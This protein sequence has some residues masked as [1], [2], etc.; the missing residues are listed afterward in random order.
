MATRSMPDFF[1]RGVEHRSRPLGA[2]EE[3][4]LAGVRFVKGVTQDQT[5]FGSVY[6]R[7]SSRRTM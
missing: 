1:D 4:T 6:G 7:P 5:V 3:A 2:M